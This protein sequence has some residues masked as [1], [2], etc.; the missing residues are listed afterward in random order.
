LPLRQS[1]A[2][3]AEKRKANN[4]LLIYLL[5][6]VGVHKVIFMASDDYR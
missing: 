5:G 3:S 1:A 2:T 6:A 4:A